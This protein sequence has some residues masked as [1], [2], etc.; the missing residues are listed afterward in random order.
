[1][2][3]MNYEASS[4][5]KNFI[6]IINKLPIDAGITKLIN[7]MVVGTNPIARVL[8]VKIAN[9]SCVTNT[10]PTTSNNS[11]D[12][13]IA[14]IKKTIDIPQNPCHQFTSIPKKRNNKKYCVAKTRYRNNDIDNKRNNS[15]VSAFSNSL[16]S[17]M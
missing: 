10:F 15:V 11:I 8:A 16:I 13:I 1:M 6:P 4:F 2:P 5:L 7:R 14:I 12:G 17:Q 9:I 3:I